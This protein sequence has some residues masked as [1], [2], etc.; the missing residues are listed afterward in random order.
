M[1]RC[2]FC[3]NPINLGEQWHR[4]VDRYAHTECLNMRVKEQTREVEAHA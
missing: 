1:I 2:V 3:R 4:C